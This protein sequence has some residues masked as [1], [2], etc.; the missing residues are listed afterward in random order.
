MVEEADTPNPQPMVANVDDDPPVPA[1]VQERM[2]LSDCSP[3][4]VP[5]NF[6]R[7]SVVEQKRAPLPGLWHK[8][9]TRGLTAFLLVDLDALERDW[10]SNQVFVPLEPGKNLYVGLPLKSS[11]GS[12]I[13]DFL[14]RP[15]DDELVDAVR[16]YS[17]Y[18]TEAGT[19]STLVAAMAPE[20]HTLL[21]FAG[22][23]D[24]NL[25]PTAF[26]FV[27]NIG[28][29]DVLPLQTIHTIR[30]AV[31]RVDAT[32]NDCHNPKRRKCAQEKHIER[33][34][35]LRNEFQRR[36]PIPEVGR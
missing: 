11:V 23:S 27:G 33:A 9:R 32:A 2:Q 35:Q 31:K 26:S 19:Q 1:Y 36:N 7:Y 4:S 24:R 8:K 14:Y 15:L 21:D 34:R 5:T 17:T 20:T 18:V 12:T 3:V 22:W 6:G 13:T 29:S 10:D 25:M 30:K 16:F 28:E